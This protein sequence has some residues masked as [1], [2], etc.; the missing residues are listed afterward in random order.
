MAEMENDS[1]LIEA[2]KNENDFLQS[3]V[4]SLQT[5][6]KELVRL[7]FKLRNNK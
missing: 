7:I 1:F 3:Q 6:N 5:Q 4:K 2:L